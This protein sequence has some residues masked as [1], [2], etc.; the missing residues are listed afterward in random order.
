MRVIV[1][2]TISI[3]TLLLA[4]Q[5]KAISLDGHWL[6]QGTATLAS[7]KTERFRCRV[8]YNAVSAQAFGVRAVCAN[9]SIKII[10]T[11]QVL[12]VRANTY[13]GEFRNDAYDVGARVRVIVRGERQFVTLSASEGTGRLDLKRR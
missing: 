6:G 2:C 11:G 13:V 10:Q 4:P 1:S 7:G 3:I 5:A 8:T 9:P 12:R